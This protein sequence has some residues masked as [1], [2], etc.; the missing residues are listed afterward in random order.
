MKG[1]TLLTIREIT[2]D[3]W[4]RIHPVILAMDPPKATGHRLG[5]PGGFW[6]TI[7]GTG[8]VRGAQVRELVPAHH[9]GDTG[10]RLSCGYPASGD[11]GRT[12]GG[13]GGHSCR[14]EGLIPL[15]APEVRRLLTRLI[16]TLKH[17]TDFVLGWSKWEEAPSHRCHYKRRLSPLAQVVRL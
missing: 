2:N 9:A 12:T 13:N 3:L 6:T 4:E 5:N 8:P 11:G 16:W 15:T 1:E 7:Y 10:P 14:D 17:S